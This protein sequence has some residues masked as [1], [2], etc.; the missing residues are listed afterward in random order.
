MSN[1]FLRNNYNVIPCMEA[2]MLKKNIEAY[3][4]D[5]SNYNGQTNTF[6]ESDY[7]LYKKASYDGVDVSGTVWLNGGATLWPGGG[8]ILQEGPGISWVL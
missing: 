3:S 6:N 4:Q 5:F 7:D 8:N 2:L 1:K